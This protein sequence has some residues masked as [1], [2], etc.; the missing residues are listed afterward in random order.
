MGLPGLREIDC[1]GLKAWPGLDHAEDGAWVRRAAGGYTRRANSVQCLD[2]TDDEDVVARIAASR[3]WFQ[4]RGLRPIFRITP[5]AGPN[6]RD[7]LNALRWVVE[8]ES[9]VMI[10]PLDRSD[11]VGDSRI[12]VLPITDPA[13]LQAQGQLQKYEE[14]T[15]DRLKAIVAAIAVPA[16]GLLV[17][18]TDGSPVSAA[19]M[20]VADGIVITGNVV[21]ADGERRKGYATALMRS[22]LAWAAGAG[23]RFAALSVSADNEPGLALYGRMGYRFAYDYYYQAPAA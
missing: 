14:M 18:S 7:A 6:L 1:A 8:G 2:P 5:L 23:A 10:R 3:C 17:R 16:C 15:L 13:W 20:G 19:L 4:L 22:G 9:H 11:Y 12:E 21:T